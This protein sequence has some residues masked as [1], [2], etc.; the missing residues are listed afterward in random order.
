MIAGAIEKN[1]RLVFE[2]AEGARMDDAVAVALIMRAPNGGQFGKF[3]SPHVTAELRVMRKDLTF[4]L[5]QFLS[6]AGHGKNTKRK[7]ICQNFLPRNSTQFKQAPHRV[8]DQL[9]RT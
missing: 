5:F 7:L 2:A 8:F 1:L 4:D 6:R 3:A 9:L